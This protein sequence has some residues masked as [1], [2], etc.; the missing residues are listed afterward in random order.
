MVDRKP[1]LQKMRDALRG[2]AS[3]AVAVAFTFLVMAGLLWSGTSLNQGYEAPEVVVIPTVWAAAIIGGVALAT[4][5]TF[6]RYVNTRTG[7]EGGMKRESRTR[8]DS[9]DRGESTTES[10]P[11]G[12]ESQHGRQIGQTV[13]V[14]GDGTAGESVKGSEHAEKRAKEN[15]PEWMQNEGNEQAGQSTTGG[16]GAVPPTQADRDL[17]SEQTRT[18]SSGQSRIPDP[19]SLGEQR[20]SKPATTTDDRGANGGSAETLEDESQAHGLTES[21]FRNLRQSVVRNEFRR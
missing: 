18:R 1:T 16:S 12:P 7:D 3:T 13:D 17:P 9:D 14:S 20:E 19:D 8:N 21:Y 11:S 15:F 10:G 2:D 6:L 4:V 5:F